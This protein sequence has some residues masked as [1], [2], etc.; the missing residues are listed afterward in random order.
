MIYTYPVDGTFDRAPLSGSRFACWVICT[1][2]LCYISLGVLYHLFAFDY[3]RVFEAH[4]STRFETEIFFRGIFHEVL[5]L[6]IQLPG[7]MNNSFPC[8]GILGVE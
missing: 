1:A 3:V 2:Y 8:A 5:P 6:Y 4:L 7:K